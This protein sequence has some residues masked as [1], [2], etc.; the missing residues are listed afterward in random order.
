MLKDKIKKN[1]LEK[2]SQKNNMCKVNLLKLQYELWDWDKFIENNW[3]KNLNFNRSNIEGWYIERMKLIY[4][5][6]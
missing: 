2:A 3:K 4:D 1:L 5:P 6:T